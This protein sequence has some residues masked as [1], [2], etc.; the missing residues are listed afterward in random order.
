MKRLVWISG[1]EIGTDLA[2][3][4]EICICQVLG[5]DGVDVHLISPG[6]IFSEHF[7]HTQVSKWSFPG[8]NA[9]SGARNIRKMI[10]SGHKFLHDYDALLVDWRYVFS[11]RREL[12]E[13]SIPW[14]LVD[15][16]P[17]AY[18]GLLNHLQ[19]IY[20]KNAWGIADK[21]ATG[22]L[23]VSKEHK[24]FIIERL[25]V[26]LEIREIPAGSFPNQLLK[27]KTDPK[28]ELLLT[29]IGRIDKRRG[30]EGVIELSE[31]LNRLGISHRISVAGEG[32]MN[33][34]ME[35]QSK[36]RSNFYYLGRLEA[37]EIYS[38]LA[39]SHI[40]IMPMPDIPIWR[41]SSPLK[42]SEYLAA[43]LAIIGPSHEGNRLKGTECWDLLSTNGDWTKQAVTNI[44][45]AVDGDWGAV[46]SASVES[47]KELEWRNIGAN[48]IV[49][50]EQ[51]INSKIEP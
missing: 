13:L 22:G 2:S 10:S 36:K 27:S 21:F 33:G 41:I 51:L 8:L 40:G 39:K 29:Y 42:L 23:V 4:T 49:D 31:L 28:E 7:N 34:E 44:Y 19:K 18:L 25:N 38:L 3:T 16:G 9:I 24:N 26:E 47:S 5:E 11:L 46:V 15:R 45:S 35:S 32:D 48:L 50:L 20:W 43:G 6:S 17:P 1:R 14:F 30:T 37:R 12:R